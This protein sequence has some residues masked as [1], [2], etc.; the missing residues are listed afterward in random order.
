[1]ITHELRSL[2]ITVP[3]ALA[4]FFTIIYLV[5]T[6]H[7]MLSEK[8]FALAIVKGTLAY[9]L[10]K[11]ILSGG[12]KLIYWS[13][14]E[15]NKSKLEFILTTTDYI[16]RIFIAWMFLSRWVPTPRWMGYTGHYT[17]L[18]QTIGPVVIGM[19]SAGFLY[20]LWF[21]IKNRKIRI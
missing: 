21:I 2:L 16:S 19:F 13:K 20:L 5:F 3:I 1:M 12:L 7:I 11:I 6:G 4:I 10:L 15:K 8:N 9:F 14:Y 17:D 18:E